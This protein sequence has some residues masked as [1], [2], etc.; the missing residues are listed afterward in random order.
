[1]DVKLIESTMI[2]ALYFPKVDKQSKGLN[3][4]MTLILKDKLPESM[5]GRF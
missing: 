1:M 2:S 4:V 3:V 5:S